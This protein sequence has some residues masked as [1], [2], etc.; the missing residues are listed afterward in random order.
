MQMNLF[1]HV[2]NAYARA[3]GPVTN[4][5]LYND[6]A[7]SAGISSDDLHKTVEIGDTSAK[8]SAIKRTIRWHQQTLKHAGL[9]ERTANRGRWTLTKE[10]KAK[11]GLRKAEPKATM[12]AY[13]TDLGV[14]LW[15]L[16]SDVYSALKGDEPITLCLTSPP[17]PLRNSRAYGNVDAAQ[18]TDFILENLAPIVD[19]LRPGGSVCLN[20]SNDIFETGRPSRSLYLEK[21][22]I[23]IN[24]ELGLELM[25]RLCW[26]NPSKPPS[27]TQWM[28]KTR[29][30]LKSNFEP[31]YWFTNDAQLCRSNNRR[32]LQPH[33]ERMKRFIQSGGEQTSRTGSDGAY[34]VKPGSYIKPTEGAVPG[35]I[36][37]YSHTCKSQLNYKHQAR[38]SGLPAHGAPYPLA[39]AKFLIEFLTERNDLVVDP[40]GGSN[41]TGVGAEELG[42]RW[43]VTDCMYE[44]AL[45]SGGRFERPDWN[46]EFLRIAA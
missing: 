26:H 12:V 24:E 15:S 16:S 4:D 11:H 25:D 34:A 43:M 31:I 13:S 32:V 21:L 41:T 3:E 14:A 46:D 22:I 17:Y 10:G 39:L 7:K 30:Q 29:Q 27:P 38:E 23:A 36:L 28:A 44:Y 1:D 45:G 40:F 37:R 6:V 33:T 35:N 8:T 9:L 18:Y 19:N 42:R 2:L 5:D 20:I